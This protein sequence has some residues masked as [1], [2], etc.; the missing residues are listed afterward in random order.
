MWRDNEPYEYLTH[1]LIKRSVNHDEKSLQANFD[2]LSRIA[3]A[4]FS[5]GGN[6]LNL[7]NT[8]SKLL[9]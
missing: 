4:G 7:L 3:V 2:A 1:D 6:K 8:R 5:A 9:T